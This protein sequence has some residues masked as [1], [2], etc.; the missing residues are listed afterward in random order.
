MDWIKLNRK[1]ATEILAE[2]T[3]AFGIQ[4]NY[5]DIADCINENTRD[6]HGNRL[7]D[8]ER[9]SLLATLHSSTVA[10]LGTFCFVF[11]YERYKKIAARY[12]GR[13]LNVGE[14]FGLERYNDRDKF[15]EAYPQSVIDKWEVD[16]RK[17]SWFA[18]VVRN[19]FAHAQ[20]QFVVQGDKRGVVMVNA[21]DGLD[22][23]FSI[24][25]SLPE[26]G[27]LIATALNKFIVTVVEGGTHEPLTKLLQ[28]ELG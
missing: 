17:K 18:D 26:F 4:V 5:G 1:E 6:I 8:G 27:H 15:L 11:P 28:L 20:S 19:S 24:F 16:P 10:S 23:D 14:A 25:M 3:G 13:N 2:S 7:P 21:R 22:P 12:P 9:C